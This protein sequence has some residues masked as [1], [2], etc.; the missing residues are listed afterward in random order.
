MTTNTKVTMTINTGI[1]DKH[2]RTTIVISNQLLDQIHAVAY[3][4]RIT[5]KSVIEE[6]LVEYMSNKPE[7]I[8][9]RPI[10]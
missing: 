1:P 2:T 7:R 4:E 8:K 9:R 10:V 5:I 6:A 3:Y